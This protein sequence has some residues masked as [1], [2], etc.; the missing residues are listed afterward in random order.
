MEGNTQVK[1]ISEYLPFV[2]YDLIKKIVESADKSG[3]YFYTL[4]DKAHSFARRGM[5]TMETLIDNENNR[6]DTQCIRSMAMHKWSMDNKIEKEDNSPEYKVYKATITTVGAIYWTIFAIAVLIWG[7]MLVI[8]RGDHGVGMMIAATWFTGFIA[9]WVFWFIWNFI[10]DAIYSSYDS[11][12]DK[13]ADIEE[14]KRIHNLPYNELLPYAQESAVTKWGL[15]VLCINI[16]AN[17]SRFEADLGKVSGGGTTFFHF[18]SQGVRFSGADIGLTLLSGMIASGRNR[19]INNRIKSIE[20][21]LLYNN[22]LAYF[23]KVVL[24]KC[25]ISILFREPNC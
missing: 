3:D 16:G 22:I 15:E 9:F 7:T 4:F 19:E 11:K 24:K 17:F 10:S 25:D 12:R 14:L 1:D 18:G 13:T 2:P 5:F 23:Y 20:I 6:Q 21:M 8:H